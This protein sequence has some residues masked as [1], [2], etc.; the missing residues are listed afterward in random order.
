MIL[1]T[2]E[3][4]FS[5]KLTDN[6]KLWFILKIYVIELKVVVSKKK[7]NITLIRQSVIKV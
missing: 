4:S 7:G 2:T 1:I 5:I 6:L 3:N